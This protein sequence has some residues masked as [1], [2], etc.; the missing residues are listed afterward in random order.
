MIVRNMVE[1]EGTHRE[2]KAENNNWSSKRIL[3]KK[4]NM[5]F[6][7]HET[8]IYAGSETL[9][10]YK[11]HLEAVYCIEGEGEIETTVDGII[12]PIKPGTMYALDQHDKHYLRAFDE[13]LRL[14][15]VFNPPLEGDEVHD[16]D[17]SYDIKLE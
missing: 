7:L 1:I 4:D 11:N 3:L 9:I 5:G 6:S 12:Y 16:E 14:I 8:I 17:G 13:D 10:W 15:C 2:V